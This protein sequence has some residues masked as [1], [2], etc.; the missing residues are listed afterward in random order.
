MWDLSSLTRDWTHFPC[1]G[2]QILNQRTTREVP[3]LPVFKAVIIWDFLSHSYCNSNCYKHENVSQIVMKGGKRKG[4]YSEQKKDSKVKVLVTQLCLTLWDSMDCSPLGSPVHGLL[5]V[6]ILGGL[7]LPSPGEIFP[8][9]GLNLGLLHCRQI[10]YHLSLQGG[11]GERLYTSKT[12]SKIASDFTMEWNTQSRKDLSIT[13]YPCQTWSTQ[14]QRVRVFPTSPSNSETPPCVLQMKSNQLSTWSQ[15]QIG[16]AK[17]PSIPHNH[18]LSWLEW[19]MKLTVI[20][21]LLDYWFI[22]IWYN[23]EIARWKRCIKQEIGKKHEAFVPSQ[24]LSLSPNVHVFSNQK[25]VWT[26]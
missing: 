10:L 18:P 3:Q 5:Q 1:T 7:T 26:Q 8:T 11:P 25:D 21:Y 6:R 19:S 13:K 23:S 16:N 17:P 2:R 22:I 14:V 4:K 12:E 9:L 24:I 20:L 15:Q